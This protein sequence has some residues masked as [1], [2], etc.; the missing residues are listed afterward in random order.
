MWKVLID[1]LVK[2][3]NFRNSIRSLSQTETFDGSGDFHFKTILLQAIREA[4]AKAFLLLVAIVISLTNTPK[5]AISAEGFIL[6][7]NASFKVLQTKIP[8]T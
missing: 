6:V 8:L 1:P 3:S 2:Y 4:K 7:P 5:M